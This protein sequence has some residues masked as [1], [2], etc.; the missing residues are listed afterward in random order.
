VIPAGLS[1]IQSRISAIE[2]RFGTTM[3]PMAGA[4]L[5]G[6][7]RSRFAGVLEQ[8]LGA[9]ATSPTPS[10]ARSATEGRSL[11][12]E[13]LGGAAGIGSLTGPSSTRYPTGTDIVNE[14]AR[15][16]GTPYVFGSADPSVGLD[17]SGLT[18]VAFA[19]FGID[20]PHYTGSQ[21]QLGRKVSSLAEAKPGDLLFFGAD[22][23][24]MGIYLGNGRMLHAPETG[25][26]VRIQPVRTDLVGIR[27]LTGA[28]AAGLPRIGGGAGTGAT[29]TVSGPLDP[30]TVPYA[31]LFADAARRTGVPANLLAAV[32]QVESSFRPE[33]VSPA[34]AQGLMQLMPATAA[35]LGVADPF[36]PAQAVDG[37]ARM[38]QGLINQF[39]SVPLALAAYNAGPNAVLRAGGVPSAGVQRYV[40]KV[41]SFAGPVG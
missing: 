17:C 18:K 3:R 33:V 40:D 35:G 20:L 1:S 30:S 25:D 9:S 37:A 27:R 16:L 7:E 28:D 36:D 24:H 39:G 34:G 6:A 38:L 23:G 4:S 32:A 2:S 10:G 15:Y 26:V 41:L 12:P 29:G 22:V 14:A 8:A 5:D 21:I 19:R 11:R 13:L 31:E